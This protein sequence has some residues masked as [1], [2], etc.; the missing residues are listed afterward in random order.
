VAPVDDG[1]VEVLVADDGPG[2]PAAMLP[3]AFDRFARG[4][5]VRRRAGGGAGLGLA[6]VAALV[7]AHGG[8]ADLGNG[9]P[10]GGATARVRLPVAGPA[11]HHRDR[12]RPDLRAT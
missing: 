2:F 3:T 7:R 4:D 5:A 8:T 11:P 1:F 6:I 10:L 9:P 12:D